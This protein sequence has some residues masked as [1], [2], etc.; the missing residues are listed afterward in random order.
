MKNLKKIIKHALDQG[1]NFFDTAMG[2]Q[3]GTSEEY[4]GRAI[5]EFSKREDVVIAAKFMPRS[6]EQINQG[7]SARE[8]IETCIMIV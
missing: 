8:H 1:I 6:Q 7:I 3:G 2:Y 4:L 5:K